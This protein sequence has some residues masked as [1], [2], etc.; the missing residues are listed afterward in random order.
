VLPSVAVSVQGI[1]VPL[2]EPVR[3]VVRIAAVNRIVNPVASCAAGAADAV[4]LVTANGYGIT[5]ILL[6]DNTNAVAA[7]K[8]N[9]V[10][11]EF[12]GTSLV[13]IESRIPWAFDRFTF[14]LIFVGTR[15]VEAQTILFT[16][17]SESNLQT[18]ISSCVC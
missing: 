13:V 7:V 11:A 14:K 4:A 9:L 15:S 10:P 18:T 1:E 12:S 6:I 5:P 16:Y 8:S 2:V 17:F 3:S